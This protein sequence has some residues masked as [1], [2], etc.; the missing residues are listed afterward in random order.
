MLLGIVTYQIAADLDL[1]SLIELCHQT[2]VDGFELRTTHAHGV[3]SSLSHGERAAVKE[4]I[5]ESGVALWGLG[6]TCEYDSPDPGVV[7]HNIEQTRLFVELARDV[8]ARGVKVRPNRLH[9]QDG[10]DV[11]ETL[12]Q[13]GLAL[14]RCGDLA[15]KTGVEIWLE[16]HGQGTSL[17]K[18]VETIMRQCDHSSV[19]VCWN[20]NP[21]D[22]DNGSITDNFKRLQP[23]IRSVHI[24][25]LWRADY[26]WSDLFARLRKMKYKGFCLA[27]IPAS[28]EPERLLHYYR[29]LWLQ[30][31][32]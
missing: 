22:L 30:L 7:E 20:S 12:K 4:Q 29:A 5:D 11:A 8:G 17:P 10:V 1:T 23:W 25:E 15:K 13:I 2:Q 24:N 26:P 3:E 28:P 9:Q 31:S 19:G 27:E 18:H 16:V 14:R 6:T 21:T 32:S